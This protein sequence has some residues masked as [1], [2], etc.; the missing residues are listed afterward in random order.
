MNE[1]IAIRVSGLS[2]SYKLY[3][4]PKDRLKE[5]LNPFGKI[6]HANRKVLDNI[7]FEI[8]KGESIGIIGRNGA[9][10]STLLKIIT[11]VLSPTSG[12]VQLNGKVASLLELGAGFN[13]EMTGYENINFNASLLG[14]SSD[15]INNKLDSI[16]SFADIGE[17]IYQPVKTY[18]SGMYVRLAFAINVAIEP[19]ILIVDEALSVG[20]SL[21]QKKCFQHIDKIVASGTTLLFVSHEQEAIRTITNRAALLK[22]GSISMIGTSSEVILEYRRQLHNEENSYFNNIVNNSTP[23]KNSILMDKKYSFGEEEAT[24]CSVTTLDKDDNISKHFQIGEKISIV[25]ECIANT[26]LKNINVAFRIRNKEGV[27][28]TSWGTLNELMLDSTK[29]NLRKEDIKKN[30]R[31]KVVFSGICIMAQNFYE[32]QATVTRE[33]DTCYGQQKILHWQDEAAFFNVSIKQCRHVVG[34]V[35]DIGLRSTYEILD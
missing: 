17:Y 29:S 31:F 23:L 25:I 26:E 8:K 1:N 12:E 7:N 21:F 20:D 10:K 34:G 19:D 2:K 16:L 15:E 24:I 35:V 9:G 4:N 18:S 3:D 27:K 6:Y 22:D 30:T 14:L 11:G 13:P 5:A 32:I 28:I 33:N